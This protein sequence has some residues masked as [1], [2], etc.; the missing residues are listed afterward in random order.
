MTV[1][2]QVN[3]PGVQLGLPSLQGRKIEHRPVWL[4][5]R[6]GTFTCIGL[7]ERE[8]RLSIYMSAYATASP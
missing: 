5:L 6:R 2:E 3:R 1:Y 8:G 4:E 7:Q